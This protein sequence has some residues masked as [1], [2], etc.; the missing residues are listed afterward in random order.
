MCLV[1]E[2]KRG[3]LKNRHILLN[4]VIDLI[5][6]FSS[7]IIEYLVSSLCYCLPGSFF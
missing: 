3:N 4:R 1:N 5:S 7:H 2:M 6:V